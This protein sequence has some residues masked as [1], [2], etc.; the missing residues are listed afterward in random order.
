MFELFTKYNLICHNQSVLKPSN[1]SI[2]KLLSITHEIYKSF[3][4]GLDVC[5]SFLGI[6]KAFVKIWHKCLLYK[7]KKTVFQVTY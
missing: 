1:S 5:D 3:D 6:S 4:D 2:N 7:L